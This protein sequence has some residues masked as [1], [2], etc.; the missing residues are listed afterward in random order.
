LRKKLGALAQFDGTLDV[1]D[2]DFALRA[3]LNDQ[4]IALL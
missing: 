2:G 1:Q 3:F 4:R